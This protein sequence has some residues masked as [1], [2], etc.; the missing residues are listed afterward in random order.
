MG[1]FVEFEKEE[2]EQSI[3]ERFE[4]IVRLYPDGL[5]VKFKKHF[6]TYEELN[7]T[8]NRLAHAI[9]EKD[10][11]PNKLVAVLF[12]PGMFEA[13][14]IAELAEDVARMSEVGGNEKYQPIS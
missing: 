9:L 13:P 2:I 12:E 4:K 10:R 14:T 1:T 7:Y 8:A 6:L 3:T 11:Q 5:A